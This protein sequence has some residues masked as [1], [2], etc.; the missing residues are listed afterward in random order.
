MGLLDDVPYFFLKADADFAPLEYVEEVLYRDPTCMGYVPS[1][2]NHLAA[3]IVS[4]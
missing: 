2:D 3:P 4:P 1:V